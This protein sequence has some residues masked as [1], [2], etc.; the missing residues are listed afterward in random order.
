[1][2]NVHCTYTVYVGQIGRSCK[3][4]SSQTKK[5]FIFTFLFTNRIQLILV[6]APIP[7]NEVCQ[8]LTA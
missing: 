7:F 8:P 2:Y 6:N 1:M 4:T 3:K 5:C